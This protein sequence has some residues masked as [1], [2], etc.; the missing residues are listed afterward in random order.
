MKPDQ[1]YKCQ[2]SAFIS[3]SQPRRYLPLSREDAADFARSTSK[4]IKLF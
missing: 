1:A 3:Q 2:I 4:S